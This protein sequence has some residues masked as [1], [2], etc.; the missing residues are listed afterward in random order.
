VVRR[1]VDRDFNPWCRAL[2]NREYS[3]STVHPRVDRDPDMIAATPTDH[4]PRRLVRPRRVLHLRTMRSPHGRLF[5]RT[6]DTGERHLVCFPPAPQK[7]SRNLT[8]FPA[9]PPAAPHP[10]SSPPSS[11]TR[12]PATLRKPHCWAGPYSAASYPS[13]RSLSS[14]PTHASKTQQQHHR[15]T[16]SASARSDHSHT[17]SGPNRYSTSSA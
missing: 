15:T 3:S 16:T 4:D 2:D 11:P 6:A 8:H 10:P 13:S 7:T 5:R 12:S 9:S 17:A 14:S 1:T